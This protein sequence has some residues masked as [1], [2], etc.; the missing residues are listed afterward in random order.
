MP[1]KR[2]KKEKQQNK[3]RVW[4]WTLRETTTPPT[5]L[6]H[7]PRKRDLKTPKKNYT[8]ILLMRQNEDET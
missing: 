8:T 2:K 3:W 4:Q 1:A 7:R 6:N 5:P